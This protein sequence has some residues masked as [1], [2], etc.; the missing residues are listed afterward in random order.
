MA[1]RRKNPVSDRG[2]DGIDQVHEAQG[3]PLKCTGTGN[4]CLPGA[5]S[6]PDQILGKH[7]GRKAFRPVRVTRTGR[8]DKQISAC[9]TEAPYGPS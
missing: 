3:M 6:A 5:P 2:A 1:T 4:L 9:C 8:D 7:L